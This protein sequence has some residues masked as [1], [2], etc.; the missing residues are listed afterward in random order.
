MQPAAVQLQQPAEGAGFVYAAR[1]SPFGV[2]TP[3][4][5]ITPPHALN[6]TGKFASPAMCNCIAV[7][8]AMLVL[9]PFSF[10]PCAF[11]MAAQAGDESRMVVCLQRKMA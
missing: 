2:Q 4:K 9:L 3:K 7:G 1:A 11:V 8:L 6:S 5:Q 10:L